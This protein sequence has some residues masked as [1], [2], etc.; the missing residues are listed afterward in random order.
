MNAIVA[1]VLAA[2]TDVEQLWSARFFGLDQDQRFVLLI[3]TIGCATAIIIAAL[4]IVLGVVGATQRR[5]LEAELKREML[6]RGLMPDEI[7]KVIEATAPK[8]A[9]DRWLSCRRSK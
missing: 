8:D 4:G 9:L 2:A 3:V 5:R 6:D 1:G 7:T